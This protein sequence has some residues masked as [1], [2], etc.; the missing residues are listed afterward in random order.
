MG[1]CGVAPFARPPLSDA[2]Y[3]PPGKNEPFCSCPISANEL[4][5][6]F[7]PSGS[8]TNWR[9]PNVPDHSICAAFGAVLRINSP[10][11]PPNTGSELRT[12]TGCFPTFQTTS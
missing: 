9:S 7:A 5:E 4:Y 8:D 10:L 12:F 2:G 1:E 3:D 11:K 6:V